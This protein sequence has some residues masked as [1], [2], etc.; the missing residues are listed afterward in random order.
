M[1]MRAHEASHP[2]ATPRTDIGGTWYWNLYPGARCDPTHVSNSP[3]D[4]QC[5]PTEAIQ[6]RDRLFA[7]GG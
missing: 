4:E 7:E 2:D 6:A 3:P 1:A 5:L